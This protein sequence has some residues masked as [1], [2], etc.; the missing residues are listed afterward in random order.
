L[1]KF[2]HHDIQ[3]DIILPHF[4]KARRKLIKPEFTYDAWHEQDLDFDV[5][6]GFGS[7]FGEIRF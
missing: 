4:P 1:I 5:C 7:D 3:E 6:R 2:V